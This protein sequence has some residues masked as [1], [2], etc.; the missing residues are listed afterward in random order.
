MDDGAATMG[1]EIDHVTGKPIKNKERE[2]LSALTPE[3]KAAQKA[4]RAAEKEAKRAAK[5]ASKGAAKRAGG[6]DAAD[7]PS[8]AKDAA[9]DVSDTIARL[10]TTGSKEPALLSHQEMPCKRKL[11]HFYIVSHTKKCLP[12][13]V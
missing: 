8:S 6:D 7:D 12:L 13:V 11:T 3:E 4:A 2:L 10:T 1:G 5:K 9:D